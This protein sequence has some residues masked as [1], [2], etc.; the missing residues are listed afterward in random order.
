MAAVLSPICYAF[1]RGHAEC[2]LSPLPRLA[3]GIALLMGI[4]L[5]ASR[6]C[7]WVGSNLVV[8]VLDSPLGMLLISLGMERK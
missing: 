7:L 1:N 4:L 8:A 6:F 2:V 3:Q 5:F